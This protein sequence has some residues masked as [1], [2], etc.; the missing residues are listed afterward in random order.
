MIKMEEEIQLHL[1]ILNKLQILK[2]NKDYQSLIK[3]NIFQKFKIIELE[4]SI[5]KLKI[6]NQL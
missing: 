4:F 2:N 3:T 5:A 1:K 6:H